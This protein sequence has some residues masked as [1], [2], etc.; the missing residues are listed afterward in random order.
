M[1]MNPCTLVVCLT[2][3]C[4][5]V[6]GSQGGE[7]LPPSIRT[8]LDQR[9]PGWRV[10]DI[11]LDV[12][13]TAKQRLGPEPNVISGDFDGNGWPDHALLIEYRNTDPRESSTYFNE[14]V[15][16]LNE[17]GRFRLT[18]L[19]DRQPGPHPGVYLTLQK[20]GSEGL[21]FEAKKKFTYATDS[22]GEWFLGKGGGSYIFR[23][24]RFR[25]VIEAD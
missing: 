14:V 10:A 2:L 23:D 24:G 17:E 22:I 18:K 19:R 6:A 12:R 20:K 16:F 25:F 1:T 3:A 9:Y 11:S 8:V 21:D 7:G 13:T 4:P 5:V 15:A